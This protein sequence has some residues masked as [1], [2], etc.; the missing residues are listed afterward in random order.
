MTLMLTRLMSRAHADRFM[1]SFHVALT[2]SVF[3]FLAM[4]VLAG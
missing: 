1:L 2:G 3:A 4:M